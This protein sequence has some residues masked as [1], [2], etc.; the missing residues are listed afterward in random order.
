MEIQIMDIVV[1]LNNK[2]FT[3]KQILEKYKITDY[4]LKKLLKTNGYTCLLYTS[5]AADE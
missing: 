5:D 3:K 1:D 2:D 4:T